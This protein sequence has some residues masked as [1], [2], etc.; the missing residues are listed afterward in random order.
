MKNLSALFFAAIL[1]SLITLG[2]YK[3]LGLDK[4]VVTFQEQAATPTVFTNNTASAPAVASTPAPAPA[5]TNARSSAPID[6]IA[7][8]AKTTPAVVHIKSTIT[9]ASLGQQQPGFDIFKDF[10][11]DDFNLGDPYGG[12]GGERQG[13]GSGVII[14]KDGFI[15]TNNHVVADATELEVVLNDNRS[16]SAEVIGTDPSTDLAV[17]KINDNNLPILEL[18]NSDDVQVG[19]WVLAVGNPFNLASTVT[20][21]IVSAKGRNINIL[22]DQYAIESFIQTDAAVNPGNSGGALVNVDGDLVG[23]NT[24]IASRTGSYSGYSFAVPVNI[25]EKVVDDLMSYG[26]VQRAY[27]GVMIRDL[28]SKVAKELALDISQGVY[29]DDLLATGAAK[30]AGVQ[31]GDVIVKVDGQSVRSAPELQELIGRKRPGDDASLTINRQGKIKTISVSLTN[32]EGNTDIVKSSV[33]KE[34]VQRL[35]VEME[36]LND[37]EMNLYGVENGVKVNRIYPGI[38]SKNTEMKEG[39]IITEIDSK[40]INSV[41]DINSV[42]SNKNG[43]VLIEGIYPDDPTTYY[44]GFGL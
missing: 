40:K 25:V 28:D 19:E 20:A 5:K 18:A 13:A 33:S 36:E 11:G 1:G 32:R 22:S 12:Q 7:A 39:F 24:A 37:D 27:L 17:I 34:L 15:V 2:T 31:K 14:S 26:T 29:V 23:I 16:Y 4:K 30:G 10:F 43:G 8:A 3:G 41:N 9:T 6:F 38:I 21:G 35:G 44:Y 42:L